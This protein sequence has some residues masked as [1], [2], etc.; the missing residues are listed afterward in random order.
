M[1]RPKTTGAWQR[2]GFGVGQTLIDVGCGPGYATLDLAEI[3]GPSG[4]VVAIDRSRRFLDHLESEQRARGIQQIQ[5]VEMDLDNARLSDELPDGA[6][7]AW[8]RWV[9]AFVQNP[10]A[11]LERIAAA[12][13][14]GG[15]LVIFEYFD[16][17]TW[18]LAPRSAAHE[19]FVEKVVETWR[20]TGG[21][22][23]VG[24]SIPGWLH[25]MGF[26]LN[27]TRSLID[28]I[29][30]DHDIWQWPKAFIDAG[31]D[32]MWTWVYRRRGQPCFVCA[33]PIRMVRQGDFR[34]TTYFCA[35]CQAS[36]FAGAT[37]WEVDGGS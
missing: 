14:P 25:G 37:S 3:V 36:T 28:I 7:G 4:R 13:K 1:W 22:T 31:V 10:R 33:S 27:S 29:G 32:R 35:Q 21:E 11:L 18:K 15:K 34:R 5:T 6:D 24:M 9:Y 26:T 2:A 23:E 8:G 19:L 17:S 30:P 16:Y 20:A 12:V